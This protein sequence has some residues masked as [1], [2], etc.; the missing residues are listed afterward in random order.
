METGKKVFASHKKAVR[1]RA[2]GKDWDLAYR[3]RPIA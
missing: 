2:R 3:L 1:K